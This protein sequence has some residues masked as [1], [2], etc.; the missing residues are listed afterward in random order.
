[1]QI[2]GVGSICRQEKDR[3]QPLYRWNLRSNECR[4][5]IE[6]VYPY[7]V[8]KQHQARL[9]LGGPS[10]GPLA[11]AAHGGL[12]WLHNGSI[13]DVDFPAPATMYQPGWVLRQDVIWS[14]LNPMPESVRDRCT[15]AHEYVFLL[16]K[17]PRYFYDAKAVAEESVGRELFGN[18]RSKGDC[19]QRNDNDRRD[20]TP[21][22]Y[23]NRRS[24]WPIATQPY[25]GAH[26]ATM[27][28][29]LAE[30]CI[31]AGTKPGD[32]VLDPFGGAGTTALVADRLQ[33]DSAI[34]ELNPAY[35]SLARDRINT[36]AGMFAPAAE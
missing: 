12:I 8:A 5:V 10:S 31:K 19:D 7:L 1:M 15:K 2:T 9:L 18:I 23:R 29:E 14:K 32:M 6:E 3:R 13:P 30:T 16:S 11:E 34:I 28:P 4:W 24:V 27:P 17:G 36:E 33:R 21:T 26:F 25:S 22:E 20:M 35:A